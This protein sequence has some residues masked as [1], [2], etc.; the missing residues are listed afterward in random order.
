M[1]SITGFMVMA[2]CLMISAC[3]QDG[4]PV[5]A[6]A[7]GTVVLQSQLDSL[8]KAKNVEQRVLE[9]AAQQQQNIEAGTQ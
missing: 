1:K 9:A 8:E 2:L 3:D 5:K 4:K 7:T 6:K